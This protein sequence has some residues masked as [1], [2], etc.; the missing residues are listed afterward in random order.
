MKALKNII[1]YA[2]QS[3]KYAQFRLKAKSFNAPTL[4]VLT[5]H[6]TL[7]SGDPRRDFEQP[8]MMI[9][10]EHLKSHIRWLKEIG[11]EPISLTEWRQMKSN[12]KPGLYFAVT[13]DD[14][15]KDN[16]EFITEFLVGQKIHSTVFL[17]ADYIGTDLLFWPEKLLYLLKET[18]I[19]KPEAFTLPQFNWLKELGAKL[20]WPAGLPDTEELDP[21]V[22]L[23][24]SLDDATIHQNVD[25]TLSATFGSSPA[26]S[27][28]TQLV[29]ANDIAQMLSTGFIHFGSHT[30]RHS[31]LDK[32]HSIQELRYEIEES[33][34]KIS[35]L[36]NMPTEIFCYPNG[37]MSTESQAVVDASYAIACTTVVGNNQAT[38]PLLRLRRHNLHDGNSSSKLSFFSTLSKG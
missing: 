34:R 16:H 21:V 11:G 6:R 12:L 2:V 29:D 33:K 7:P 25:A 3:V 10:P 14:G 15:W 32:L 24:K 27:S 36:T 5:Y 22:N 4:Y 17:V 30:C 23:C 37:S 38:T 9:A 19:S 13:F 26:I 1:K 28:P 8:G 31:R 20:E 18:A 35:N